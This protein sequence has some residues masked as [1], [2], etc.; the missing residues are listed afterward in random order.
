MAQKFNT[1]V[2]SFSVPGAYSGW[3][4]STQGTAI[5]ATKSAAGQRFVIDKSHEYFVMKVQSNPEDQFTI[6]INPNITGYNYY[7]YWH[8]VGDYSINGVGGPYTGDAT[9]LFPKSGIYRLVISGEFPAIYFN[10]SGDAL[11]LLDVEQWGIQKWKSFA[12]AFLACLN[13]QFS[14]IDAPDWSKLEDDSMMGAFTFTNFNAS[15]N[16]WDVSKIR[17]FRSMF[18]S[19][20]FNRPINNWDVSQA[21]SLR[22]LFGA[23]AAGAP[24]TTRHHS[25]FNQRLDK[26]DVG[27]CENFQSTFQRCLYFNQD[28]NGWD[29]SKAKNTRWMFTYALSFDQPLSDWDVSSVE[30]MSFMFHGKN[31]IP[32]SYFPPDYAE[33]PESVANPDVSNWNTASLVEAAGMFRYAKKANPDIRNWTLKNV[34]TLH[35][36]ALGSNFSDENYDAFLLS[37]YAQAVDPEKGVQLNVP[38]NA[39]PARFSTDSSGDPTTDP[40]AAKA[41]LVAN[42][43]WII[44]DSGPQN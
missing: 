44:T 25:L 28:I 23:V 22:G 30:D 42:R 38:F 20:L 15:V 35:Q 40:A 1:N 6:P 21:T 36:F 37:A 34:K 43:G 11:Y 19:T 5:F 31:P 33:W 2:G 18:W 14:A 27:N 3:S 39:G 24:F 4:P 12:F 10:M 32:P 8:K 17:D 29:V 16:N 26:W 13:V 7:V 41:Y 9:I